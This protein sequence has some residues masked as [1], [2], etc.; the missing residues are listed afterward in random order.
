VEGTIHRLS[1]SDG[2]VPKLPV[3]EAWVG[4]EGMEGDRQRDLR[5]HGGPR[6][7]L[8]LYS[9]ERIEELRTEGHPIEPGTVGENLTLSGLDWPRLVPGTRLA[10]GDEVEIEITAYT[11]PCKNIAG[12]FR[13]GVFTRISE[14]LHPGW[15]RV[16]AR[17]LREGRL[18]EG[19]AVRVDGAGG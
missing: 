18:R 17:V 8:C 2:G 5:F 10:L 6:R 15:S 4:T 16:Y 19:D 13:D 3:R 11:V 1:R 9:L 14:K 12:S 7:A